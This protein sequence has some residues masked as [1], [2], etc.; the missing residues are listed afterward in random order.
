MTDI[1]SLERMSLKKSTPEQ[2]ANQIRGALSSD[3]VRRTDRKLSAQVCR[4]F[5]PIVR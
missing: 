4:K 3:A 5:Q 2:D 1:G